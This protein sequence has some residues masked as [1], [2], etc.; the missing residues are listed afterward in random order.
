[1]DYRT[2]DHFSASVLPSEKGRSNSCRGDILILQ[3]AEK[4]RRA[5]QEL[6]EK[7]RLGQLAM[8]E[9]RAAKQEEKDSKAARRKSQ[10]KE[11]QQLKQQF[12]EEQKARCRPSDHHGLIAFVLSIVRVSTVP[13][14]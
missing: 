13:F 12:L 11:L 8:E 7:R 14:L 6:A 2:Y 9:A 10:A 1:M 3:I 4:Q 5:Q